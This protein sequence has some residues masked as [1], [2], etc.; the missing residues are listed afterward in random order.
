MTSREIALSPPRGDRHLSYPIDHA[1]RFDVRLRRALE[2]PRLPGNLT[3]FQQGW[4]SARDDAAADIDFPTLQ[5][6]MKRAKSAVTSDLD[7]YLEVF[8][9]A[10]EQAG[11]TVHIASDASAAN[12]VILDI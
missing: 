12:R 7:S 9:T 11:A 10:A 5:A 3:A 2:N 4:R 8:R 1:D 6:R